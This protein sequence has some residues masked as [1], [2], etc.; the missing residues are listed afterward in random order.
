MTPHIV[1]FLGT[2]IVCVIIGFY[3]GVFYERRNAAKKQ[4]LAQ[5]K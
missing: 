4:D 5:K 1:P 3:L 2:V